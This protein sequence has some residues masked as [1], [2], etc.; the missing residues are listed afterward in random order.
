MVE[1]KQSA[2][3]AMDGDIIRS[4]SKVEM[5]SV[6]IQGMF[7]VTTVY[8]RVVCYAAIAMPEVF[9]RVKGAMERDW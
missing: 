6:V 5:M 3:I 2:F 7:H 1:E 9:M 4:L 8:A